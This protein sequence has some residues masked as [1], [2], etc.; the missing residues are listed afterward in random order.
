MTVNRSLSALL[1][2]LVVL[3]GP[4][5][6]TDWFT[7]LPREDIDVKTWPEG[8][9]VAVCFVLYVEVWGPLRRQRWR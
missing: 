8:R 5:F 6:G 1:V 9:R 2:G 4:A 7:G 3:A